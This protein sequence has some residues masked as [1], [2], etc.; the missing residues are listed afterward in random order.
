MREHCR[1]INVAG[2]GF[3][4]PRRI[5]E[6]DMANGR[7]QALE[8]GRQVIAHDVH[9]VEIV[10]QHHIVH[11]DPIKDRHGLVRGVEQET[12]GVDAVQGFDGE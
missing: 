4:P 3:M 11:C 12:G 2:A 9:M 5:G 7:Q 8:H 6:L 10:L 1:Q